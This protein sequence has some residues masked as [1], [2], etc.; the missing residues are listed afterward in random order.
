MEFLFERFE[1]RTRFEGLHR[2]W[3]GVLVRPADG[4]HAAIR[5]SPPPGGSRRWGCR[6]GARRLLARDRLPA[7]RPDAIGL[8]RR[9]PVTREAIVDLDTVLQLSEAQWVIDC[10]HRR[11]PLH[12]DRQGVIQ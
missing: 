1:I 7:L 4:A 11:A 10:H 12:A 8:H 2:Q 3:T 5:R 9:V 6:R